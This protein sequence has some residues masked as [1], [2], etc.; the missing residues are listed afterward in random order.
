MSEQGRGPLDLNKL[1]VG[2]HLRLHPE[3]EDTS[4]TEVLERI[5]DKGIVLD[6]WVRV[7]LGATDLRSKDNR[8]VVAPERRRK[9]FIVPPGRRKH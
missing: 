3:P 1:I 2:G 9:P 4:L 6:P 7:V 5:L 8:L